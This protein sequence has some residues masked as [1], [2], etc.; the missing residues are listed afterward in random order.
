[1]KSNVITE[2]KM[3]NPLLVFR[4]L[5]VVVVGAVVYKRTN[6]PKKAALG[7]LI[8]FVIV[9]GLSFVADQFME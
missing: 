1:M 6:D 3:I 2:V 8:A 5:I 4:I 9:W 7:A